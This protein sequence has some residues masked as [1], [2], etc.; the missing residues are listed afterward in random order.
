MYQ[1]IG[2]CLWLSSN[3]VWM[4]GEI[5]NN[6]DGYLRWDSNHVFITALTWYALYHLVLLPLKVIKPDDRV[7][8]KYKALGM[9]PRFSYFTNWRQYEHAQ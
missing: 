1:L 9:V 6:D 8:K 4:Y 5:V 2:V 3:Y 7:T